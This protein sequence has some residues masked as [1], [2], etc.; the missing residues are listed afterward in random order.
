[1]ATI[2]MWLLRELARQVLKL[3]PWLMA[4]LG[5]GK[6]ISYEGRPMYGLHTT[7]IATLNR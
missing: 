1:M 3:T 2:Y 4:T 5:M 6:H 7:C